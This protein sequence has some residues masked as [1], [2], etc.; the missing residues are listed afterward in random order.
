LIHGILDF[1]PHN[2]PLPSKI[3][4]V[5]AVVLLIAAAFLAQKQNRFLILICFIGAV[6]P[7]I[8]DLSPGI[9][10]KHVGIFLP[11]LSFKVF[12]WHWKEY[13]GSIYDGSRNFESFVYYTL[14]FL[15]SILLIFLYR[16]KLFFG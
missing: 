9:L 7:D 14:V 3:D 4:V 16:K 2:Y 11:Q 12:P 8:V 1:L 10:N 5:L 6:F 15:I 13:S